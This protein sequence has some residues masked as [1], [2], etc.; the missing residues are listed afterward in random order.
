MVR[1]E[2]QSWAKAV[3][4]PPGSGLAEMLTQMRALVAGSMPP[5]E[6]HD[7]WYA[8][9]RRTT[10]RTHGALDRALNAVWFLLED[11]YPDPEQRVEGDTSAEELIDGVR[12]ALDELDQ[13]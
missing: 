8:T 11:Y 5:E 12:A 4:L 6:F 2:Q 9:R 13:A 3:D 7:A 10:E 1:S